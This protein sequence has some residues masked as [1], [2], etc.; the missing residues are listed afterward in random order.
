MTE[1]IVDQ[2]KLQE[3]LVANKFNAWMG[4]KITKL[5]DHSIEI[6][7]NWREEMI[8][9]PKARWTHGGILGALVDVTADFMIAAKVGAPAPTV[10]LRTDYHRAAT[11]GNLR[12]VGKIIKIGGT[13][14]TAEA[15]VFDAEGKLVASGRGVYFT[16]SI[17]K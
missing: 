4:L 16:A 7:M 10:D 1:N 15:E 11:P 14:S 6:T 2:E 12:A 9:N 17:K 8:S 3:R 5:D 13:F